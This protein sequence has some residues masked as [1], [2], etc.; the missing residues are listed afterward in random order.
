[1]D[2]LLIGKTSILAIGTEITSGQ[3]TNRNASWLSEKLVDLGVDVI[4]HEVVP[5]DHAQI[6]EAL[7]HCAQKS[8]L[9]FVTG[10]LGPTT[11]DFT[12][13]VVAEWLNQPL[14]F[15]EE[16]WQRIVKRLSELGI[17]I[18]ESNRQQCFFPKG[19]SIILNPE[20]TASAFTSSFGSRQQVW[21]LPGPP[22]EIAAVWNQGIDQQIKALNPHF[23]PLE[24]LTWQ[25]LGKSEAEL[26]EITE[27]ALK[28][29]QLQ[30]GYRA[31]RPFV[32]IKVW[33]RE[34]QQTIK[35]H[36]IQKLESAISPWIFTRQGE[37]LAEKLLKQLLGYEYVSVMDKVSQGN[38]AQRVGKLFS[39]SDLFSDL[40]QGMTWITE[41]S[42]VDDLEDWI[43]LVL[44]FAD[45][46]YLTL[47]LGGV[48][49]EG[50]F[51]VGLR[52]RNRLKKEIIQS[53]WKNLELI[54]RT[55]AYSVEIALKKW[56]EWL[57]QS[58]S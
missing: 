34:N 30:V 48:D 25:C 8:Q 45:E 21:V 17:P 38:L 49:L 5:D 20:G 27:S 3:I 39:S 4:L 26:C 56:N 31:H 51:V 13:N 28:G 12:R 2:P 42:Q 50:K 19:S 37:D 47:V 40:A 10:G 53:P 35:N 22:R 15:C 55:R 7:R 36:W 29:S 44:Q 57:E 9:I 43:D 46:D 11:D 18:A 54:D 58:T 23:Q 6:L 33:V 32:E 14:E 24:L 41:Y 52:D 1:M 16:S